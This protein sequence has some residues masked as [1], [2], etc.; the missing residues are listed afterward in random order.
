MLK[1]LDMHATFCPLTV[2]SHTHLAE[3]LS[4]LDTTLCIEGNLIPLEGLSQGHVWTHDQ[5]G[6]SG[7]YVDSRLK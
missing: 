6:L 2:C 3:V 4:V 5:Q 1:F 7:C